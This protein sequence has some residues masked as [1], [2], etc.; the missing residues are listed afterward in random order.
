ML[1]FARAKNPKAP[2]AN[3]ITTACIGERVLEILPDGLWTHPYSKVTEQQ[4]AEDV[5]SRP[6]DNYARIE[7]MLS[8]LAT[9]L[10]TAAS[11]YA[12]NQSFRSLDRNVYEA[13]FD[14]ESFVSVAIPAPILDQKTDSE[15]LDNLRSIAKWMAEANDRRGGRAGLGCFARKDRLQTSFDRG[16]VYLRLRRPAVAPDAQPGNGNFIP[17]KAKIDYDA[18]SKRYLVSDLSSIPVSDP[19]FCRLMKDRH[20]RRQDCQCGT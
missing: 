16:D 9:E 2:D 5:R 8:D 18:S 10:A 13:F 1:A 12:I 3:W 6:L 15:D 11:N 4:A 20:S 17:L 7:G 19:V 14:S